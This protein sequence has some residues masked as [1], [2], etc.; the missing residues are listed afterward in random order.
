MISSQEVKVNVSIFWNL[1]A[2]YHFKYIN[3]INKIW[4]GKQTKLKN[5]VAIP[6]NKIKELW[7]LEMEHGSTA[8]AIGPRRI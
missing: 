1:S 8:E 4:G 3:I 2:L 7:G 5:N 6:R